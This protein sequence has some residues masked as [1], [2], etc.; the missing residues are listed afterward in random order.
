MVEVMS[1]RE[2]AE[3]Y[4]VDPCALDAAIE[5][6]ESDS[7]TF[8]SLD[9]SSLRTWNFTPETKTKMKAFLEKADA[10]Q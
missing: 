7:I 10:R 1:A 8:D 5:E 9:A 4:G 3:R 2:Y 6:A